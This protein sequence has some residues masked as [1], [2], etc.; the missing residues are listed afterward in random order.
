MTSTTDGSAKIVLAECASSGSKCQSAG[1]AAGEIQLSIDT[2]RYVTNGEKLP[3]LRDLLVGTP[4][5]TCAKTEVILKGA[6]V[7]VAASGEE[8]EVF[9]THFDLTAKES[10]GIQ[11]PDPAGEDTLEANVGSKGYEEAGVAGTEELTFAEEAEVT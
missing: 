7:A 3:L 6:F 2:L 1:A 9:K 11:E 10:K 4:S 8:I 5:F